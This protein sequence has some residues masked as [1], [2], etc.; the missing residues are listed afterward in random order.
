MKRA[1]RI[2]LLGVILTMDTAA[3]VPAGELS[4]V[5]AHVEGSVGVADP[6]DFGPGA[7]IRPLQ[8]LSAESV[9]TLGPGSHA[10]LVCSTERPTFLA[11]PRQWSLTA[12]WC[13]EGRDLPLGSYEKLLA[14]ELAC[15][16]SQSGWRWFRRFAP[17]PRKIYSSLSC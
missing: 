6:A 14:S 10:D 2:Y 17:N 1:W 9:V 7:P 4:A 3:A 12:P 15:G 13:V 11:G 16:D 8:V 5:V